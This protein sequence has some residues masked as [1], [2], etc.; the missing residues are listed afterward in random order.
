MIRSLRTLAALAL[1]AVAACGGGDGPTG[2][3]QNAVVGTYTLQTVNGS[4]LP[5]TVALGPGES[6]TLRSG[7]VTLNADGSCTHR[8]DV[9]YTADGT[10]IS[11]NTTFVCTYEVDGNTVVTTDADDGAQVTAVYSNGSLTTTNQ[12]ITLVYRK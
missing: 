3:N 10:T 5:S 9:A 2:N 12:G 11:D 6:V 8:H 1:T 4:A 7:S